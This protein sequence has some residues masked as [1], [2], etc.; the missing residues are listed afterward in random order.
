[1]VIWSFLD[2][3]TTPTNSFRIYLFSYLDHMHSFHIS[4][5]SD[6]SSALSSQVHLLAVLPPHLSVNFHHL[7]LDQS[8]KSKEAFL[9]PFSGSVP[10]HQIR[11]S[12]VSHTH[13]SCY[14]HSV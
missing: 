9:Y 11:L 8:L 5:C 1:M 3:T 2:T 6:P 10:R 13:L 14:Y 7:S 4:R 12:L